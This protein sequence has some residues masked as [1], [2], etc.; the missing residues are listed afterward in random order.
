LRDSGGAISVLAIWKRELGFWKHATRFADGIFSLQ[1][2]GATFKKRA[3]KA[4]KEIKEFAHK[5][6]VRY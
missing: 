4:I 6:M 1:L 3:P 5:T 2:H